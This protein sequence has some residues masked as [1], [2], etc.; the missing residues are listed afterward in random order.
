M[1]QWLDEADSHRL[2]RMNDFAPAFPGEQHK[3]CPV[4]LKG[5]LYLFGGKNDTHQVIRMGHCG[6]E[7]LLDLPF[8]FEKGRCASMDFGQ[9]AILCASKK[10]PKECHIFDGLDWFQT[11][12][13]IKK[14]DQGGLIEHKDKVFLFGGNDVNVERFDRD[15]SDWVSLI[16]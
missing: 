2:T 3:L 4:V 13:S 12:D 6:Y 7:R 9:R 1:M 11:M 14:H 5:Q 10:N 15:F 8:K 16:V